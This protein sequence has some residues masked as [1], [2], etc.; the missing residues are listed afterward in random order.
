MSGL[1]PWSPWFPR[2]VDEERPPL[3]AA[4][5]TEPD[6]PVH[7][8]G[9]FS[10]LPRVLVLG[11]MFWSVPSVL[12]DTRTHVPAQSHSIQP[13]PADTTTPFVPGLYR[14]S[15]PDPFVMT[16]ASA[17][18]TIGFSDVQWVVRDATGGPGP[19]EWSG[20]SESV[21]V[22][23]QDRLHLKIRQIG[24]TWH[25]AEVV[26]RASFGYGTYTFQLASDVTTY[27]QN[28]VVGLF[29]YRPGPE[30]IDVEFSQWG[31]AENPNR[32]QYAVWSRSGREEVGPPEALERFSIDTDDGHSTHQFT[33]TP[34]LI[35]FRSWRGSDDIP[36]PGT[37]IHEWS[38]T[39]DDI[40][41]P[42]GEHLHLNFWL[43]GGTP[44][45]NTQE[46]ELV[47]ESVS[48]DDQ[49][50]PSDR[51]SLTSYPNPIG[52]SGTVRYTIPE[53]QVVQLELYDLLGREVA[54]LVHDIQGP[55]VHYVP[56]SRIQPRLASGVYLL[57]LRTRSGAAIRKVSV[58][59]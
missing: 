4:D 1:P 9:F 40:P 2:T 7:T 32:G 46:A 41:K 51:V 58:T 54:V 3:D 5:A 50:V 28:I 35:Q 43:V 19:N 25:G 30:E 53:Q 27:D 47:V 31:D 12:A 33:W 6:V 11:L 16:T 42:D 15:K 59:K 18:R 10:V 20:D 34:H 37:R 17:H 55:G 24:S 52:K 45:S 14:S 13:I 57:R 8:S 39:G 21:W 26:T 22:D 44:P 36:P 23:D 48:Y 29:T 38:Y 49:R 56:W